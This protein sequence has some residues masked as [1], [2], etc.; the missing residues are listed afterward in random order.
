MTIWHPAFAN[1]RAV[2]RPTPRAAPVMTATF[3]STSIGL[4]SVEKAGYGQAV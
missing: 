3:L 4:L 2:A 1:F